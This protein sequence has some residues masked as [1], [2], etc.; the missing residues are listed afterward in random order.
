M[1]SIKYICFSIGFLCLFSCQKESLTT[2]NFEPV[3]EI[4]FDMGNTKKSI[5]AGVNSFYLSPEWTN[6]S[7]GDFVLTSSFL[8][9]ASCNVDCKEKLTI[10]F[11][12]GEQDFSQFGGLNNGAYAFLSPEENFEDYKFVHVVNTSIADSDFVTNWDLNGME[13]ENISENVLK[14]KVPS[15]VDAFEA[16]LD[17]ITANGCENSVTKMINNESL[18]DFCMSSFTFL[19]DDPEEM[20]FLVAIETVGEG[21]FTYEWN[22]GFD[23][24]FNILENNG[25]E[26]SATV[27]DAN[28]CVSTIT[29]S[30]PEMNAGSCV[31]DLNYFV[32]PEFDEAI[33]APRI[34]I[35]YTNEDG[36]EYSSG[37]VT[38]RPDSQFFISNIEEYKRDE[39]GNPTR[40]MDISFNCKLGNDS[41][42]IIEMNGA[43]GSIAFSYPE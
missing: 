38:Q 33:G 1:N 4:D 41:N 8:T 29:S 24:P 28:N 5:Q 16:K 37:A 7:D 36:V 22:D 21:P 25:A 11:I 20:L 10:K 34:V 14:V 3:F 23:A 31:A 12:P 15:D 42:E 27:T 35:E 43:E 39:N 26:F 9:D 13:F 17:I 32:F 30:I 2:E 19:M 6:D 40:K 18:N